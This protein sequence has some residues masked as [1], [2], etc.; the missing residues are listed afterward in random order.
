[1]NPE[2]L[3]SAVSGL[4][5]ENMDLNIVPAGVTD[6]AEKR[7]RIASIMVTRPLTVIEPVRVSASLPEKANKAPENV[8]TPDL[9]TK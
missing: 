7:L 8:A 2:A 4:L 5:T 9:P 6:A 3:M 1:M